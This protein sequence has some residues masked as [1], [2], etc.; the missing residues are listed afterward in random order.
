MEG[1]KGGYLSEFVVHPHGLGVSWNVIAYLPN[2]VETG[3][4][5][6]RGW[7]YFIS[8]A[9]EEINGYS[10]AARN[11]NAMNNPYSAGYG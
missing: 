1:R 2:L 8:I 9:N 10:W 4:G 7:G 6:K 5:D 11:G 3:R